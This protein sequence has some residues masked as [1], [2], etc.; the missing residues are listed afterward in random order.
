M[1]A[2]MRT[3]RTCGR[4][5]F[6]NASAP[7]AALANAEGL[8]AGEMGLG[9]ALRAG[10]RMRAHARGVGDV[11]ADVDVE[12]ARGARCESACN[13]GRPRKRRS[14]V[15]PRS[16]SRAQ[17]DPSH[18]SS[19]RAR[20]NRCRALKLAPSTRRGGS[21]GKCIRVSP[22]SA[23]RSRSVSVIRSA[24]NSLKRR[25]HRARSPSG[26][27]DSTSYCAKASSDASPTT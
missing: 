21:A 4:S 11:E 13:G 9:V 23:R 16:P 19:R 5:S 17:M 24:M 12:G 6:A 7:V 10:A 18:L 14:S 25:R 2:G 15:A 27:A 1:G 20:V 3:S 8:D 22:L 26:P